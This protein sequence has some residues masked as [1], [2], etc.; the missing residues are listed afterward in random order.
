MLLAANPMKMQQVIIIITYVRFMLCFQ[1]AHTQLHIPSVSR[2]ITDSGSPDG[3]VI[4]IGCNNG[5]GMN[6]IINNALL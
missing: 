2:N 3:R 6:R 1:Y 4:I 5:I